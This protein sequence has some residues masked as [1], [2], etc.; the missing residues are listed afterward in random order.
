MQVFTR[1]G[2]FAII[3]YNVVNFGNDSKGIMTENKRKVLI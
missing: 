3:C 1:F 2:K